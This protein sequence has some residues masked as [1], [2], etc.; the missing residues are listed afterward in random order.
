MFGNIESLISL[1][2]RAIGM[3]HPPPYIDQIPNPQKDTTPHTCNTPCSV[4]FNVYLSC[5]YAS[6]LLFCEDVHN[7]LYCKLN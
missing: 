1:G 3:L 4:F 6:P 2:H 5:V 7:M